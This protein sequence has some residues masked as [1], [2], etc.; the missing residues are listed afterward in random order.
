L[1]M[2]LVKLN[3]AHYPRAALHSKPQAATPADAC[4]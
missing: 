3:D 1:Q 2:I 4:S